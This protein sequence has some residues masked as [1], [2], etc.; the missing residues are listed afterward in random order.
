MLST[1]GINV[2]HVTPRL[3]RAGGGVTEAIWG[4]ARAT[5]QRGVRH[6]A[7]A[8]QDDWTDA[9]LSNA[10]AGC[11]ARVFP[12]IGPRSA[13]FSPSLG[14]YLQQSLHTYDIVHVH[15]IRHW[16]GL[17]AR[18]RAVST[19]RPLLISLHGM[20]Y[21]EHLKRSRLRK[22]A[23]HAF[24]ENSTLRSAHCLHATSTQE[25]NSI[26]LF[27]CANPA[28]T[29]PLGISAA[30]TA[31]LSRQEENEALVRRW[32]AL[33]DKRRLLYLGMLDPK[34]GL[35]RLVAAWARLQHKFPDWQLA[36]AGPSVGDYEAHLRAE[37]NRENLTDR[38]AFL[39]PLYG[40]DKAMVLRQSD[41]FVLPSDWENFGIVVGEALAAGLP[42]VVSRTA[43]W[44]VVE[45]YEC[46]WWIEPTAEDLTQTLDF[47]FAQSRKELM[48]R[49]QRGQE[50]IA[51]RFSWESTGDALAEVY[52]WLAGRRA[53]PACVN[54]AAGAKRLE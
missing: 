14:K 41:L 30:A 31:A 38:I 20:L 34:K 12:Q 47:A 37:V 24:F 51:G 44:E 6:A 49:G 54:T 40:A 15:S 50:L 11:D 27:G 1:R 23:I 45:Q 5:M 21:P 39:G 33:R 2:L 8:V 25:L 16:P 18:R 48:R 4:M 53:Q 42:V 35:L 22:A 7:V 13:F 28:A 29:I 3:S 32:P 52:A 36:I 43:P 19:G 26:R 10:P 46:G 17:A 9:D